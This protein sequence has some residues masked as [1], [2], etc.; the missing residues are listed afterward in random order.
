MYQL[1]ACSIAKLSKKKGLH[2][3]CIK[4]GSNISR[5]VKVKTHRGFSGYRVVLDRRE[6]YLEQQP[7][8]NPAQG[9]LQLRTLMKQT[10]STK[11]VEKF[12]KF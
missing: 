5:S 12:N 11:P 6:C 1:T 7:S 3:S 8:L 10:N 2:F 9:L 4:D